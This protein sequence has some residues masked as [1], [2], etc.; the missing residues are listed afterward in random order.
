MKEIEKYLASMKQV[1]PEKARLWRQIESNIQTDGLYCEH[2]REALIKAIQ[3]LPDLDPRNDVWALLQKNITEYIPRINTRKI[4][5]YISGVAATIILFVSTY[6]L[7]QLLFH[8][9][10]KEVN[11]SYSEESVEFF[12]SRIC[13]TNPRKCS[14]ADFIELKSEIL[15]LCN[16]KLAVTNS[17]YS[18]P[19]DVDITRINERIN[20]QIVLLKSQIID[21]VE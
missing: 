8:K 19:E 10:S 21:Y 6:M 14:E 5:R 4:Y 20:R 7:Y 3:N 11:N 12:L 18:N 2:N 15:E 17:I 1:D 13:S 16:E 9:E